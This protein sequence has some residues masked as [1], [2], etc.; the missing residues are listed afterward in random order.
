MPTIEVQRDQ[1]LAADEYLREFPQRAQRALLRA[2]NRSIKSA[3]TVMVR[4]IA[5][6]TG[7][8]S[9]DVRDALVLRE[10]FATRP[11]ASLAAKLKRL[12]LIDFRAK[13]PEPSR[14]RGRGVT[15]R[16]PG[17]KG[18]VENAFIATMH[19]GHRGVFKRKT[20]ARLGIVELKGP[21]LGHVFAKYRPLGLARAREVFDTNFAHEMGFLQT[22]GGDDAGT[23]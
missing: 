18:R 3:R 4:E 17:G 13:G 11:E 6:D 23:D 5:K 2:M 10:A 7:L 20:R 15:Y 12:S 14:G 21:S 9:K 1:L 22:A 8:K 19:S 16:L